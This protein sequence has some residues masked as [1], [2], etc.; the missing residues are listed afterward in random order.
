MSRRWDAVK[1]AKVGL[2]NN[3]KKASNKHIQYLQACILSQAV[4]LSR[5]AFKSKTI[6]ASQ[7]VIANHMPSWL[8]S[9]NSCAGYLPWGIKLNRLRALMIFFFF[10]YIFQTPQI[11]HLKIP[12]FRRQK[13]Q[14][15]LC[16]VTRVCRLDAPAGGVRLNWPGCLWSSDAPDGN[17]ATRCWRLSSAAAAAAAEET[18][19]LWALRAPL[20][21][22]RNYFQRQPEHIEDEFMHHNRGKYEFIFI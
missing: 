14:R 9:K 6:T 5:P 17:T 15:Y 11:V 22:H 8:T 16:A 3:N 12:P 1:L 13:L 4:N 2:I 7:Y 20:I 10:F 18:P 19:A 21:S